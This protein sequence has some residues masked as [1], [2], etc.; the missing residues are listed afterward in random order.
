LQSY[1]LYMQYYQN[2]VFFLYSCDPK[3]P[4]GVT[5]AANG[6]PT[7]EDFRSCKM[8]YLCV[9]CVCCVQ[10]IIPAVFFCL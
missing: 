3:E 4:L 10:I 1:A 2:P 9:F 8:Q 5:I 7:E 6:L